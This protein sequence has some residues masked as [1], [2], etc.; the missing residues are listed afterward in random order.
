VQTADR[1]AELNANDLTANADHQ[2]YAASGASSDC[3]SASKVTVTTSSNVQHWFAPI[4]G[5]NQSD[6]AARASAAWGGLSKGPAMLPFIFAKCRFTTTAFGQEHWVIYKDNKAINTCDADGPPG[7]F[8]WLDSDGSCSALIDIANPEMVSSEP[9]NS[10]LTECEATLN[11]LKN[12]PVLFPVYVESSGTGQNAIYSVYGFAAFHLTG[13]KFGGSGASSWNDGA[14][15][16]GLDPTRC[17]GDC[18]G[19]KGYFTKFVTLADYELGGPTDLGTTAVSL[20][21]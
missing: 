14:A 7:G 20:G 6:V 10:F 11:A 13:W 2:C 17:T 16:G 21:R 15:T 4:L 18:R 8:G 12:Q 5:V 9:G 3:G 19:I 1:M